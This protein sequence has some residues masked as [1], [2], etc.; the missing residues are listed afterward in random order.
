MSSSS[1]SSYSETDSNPIVRR[2]SQHSRA[3]EDKVPITNSNVMPFP[4][5]LYAIL[6]DSASAGIIEWNQE[7]DKIIVFDRKKMEHMVLR[8]Y[9]GHSNYSSFSR[10]LLNYHFVRL[11]PSSGLDKENLFMHAK[12]MFLR[13]RPDLLF[14]IRR[15]T[16][17]TRSRIKNKNRSVDMVRNFIKKREEEHTSP[18]PVAPPRLETPLVLEGSTNEISEPD[19]LPFVWH[20]VEKYADEHFEFALAQQRPAS[21][22]YQQSLDYLLNS[23]VE[24]GKDFGLFGELLEC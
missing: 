11:N 10:Q 22:A 24:N 8:R 16:Q 7:G 20:T 18:L 19:E 2:A 1:S 6:E 21:A 4:A 23:D 17:Q 13:Q 9:F 15:R 12:G 14:S 3:F 5:K